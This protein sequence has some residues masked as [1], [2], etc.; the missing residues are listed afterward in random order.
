MTDCI[1][2]QKVQGDIKDAMR[3]KDAARLGTLRMLLAAIKQR[4]IDD[5]V[6]TDNAPITDGQVVAIVDKMIKQRQE[7]VVQYQQ[8]QRQDLVDK[9]NAEIVILREYLP[10]ALTAEEVAI[11]VDEAIAI[12]G[13]AT[14]KDMARVMSVIKEKAQGRADIGEISA[15]VKKRLA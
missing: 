6:L 14:I 8:G 12:V 1:L 9:E 3:G 10:Q 13:A 15:M 4:E 11:L 2:K 5:R 7:S